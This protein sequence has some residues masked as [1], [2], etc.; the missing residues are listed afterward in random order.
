MNT[1]S[2]QGDGIQTTA[3]FH[4]LPILVFKRSIFC[5]KKASYTY[6]KIMSIKLDI[7]V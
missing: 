6:F 5:F 2:K 1:I 4:S 3:L 7:F